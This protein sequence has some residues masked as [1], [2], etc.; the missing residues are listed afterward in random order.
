MFRRL[1]FRGLPFGGIKIR[2]ALVKFGGYPTVGDGARGGLERGDVG[3]H[4]RVVDFQ[5]VVEGGRLD[6]AAEREEME[7]SS[8]ESGVTTAAARWAGCQWIA[9]LIWEEM[10]KVPLRAVEDGGVGDDDL[11]F[12]HCTAGSMSISHYVR[13]R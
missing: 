3:G 10:G 8:W 5:L 7:V 1:W 9:C 4:S 6:G 11:L 13:E 2:L 12:A